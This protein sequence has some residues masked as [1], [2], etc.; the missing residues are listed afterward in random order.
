MRTV[1]TIFLK[2]L[3][4][5][6]RDR[7]TIITTVVVPLLLFPVIMGFT[8][9]IQRDATRKAHEKPLRV[10]V[11]SQDPVVEFTEILRHR[12]DITIVRDVSKENV[13]L[14]IKEEKLDGAYFFSDTYKNDIEGLR[15]GAVTFYFKSS[16]DENITK[17]RL[18]D[19]LMELEKL[20]LASRFEKLG[21]DSSITTPLSINEV[22]IATGKEIFGKIVGGLLPYIFVIFCF[23]GAMITAIDLGAGE[24]ER[25][26]L[27]TLLASPAG[28][29]EILGGKFMTVCLSGITSALLALLGLYAAFHFGVHTIKDLPPEIGSMLLEILEPKSV[30][31]FISML[32]PLTMFFSG[33]LLSISVYSKSFKEAGSIMGPVNIV[34]LLPVFI[35]MLPGI[36]LNSVTALVPLL[37][38]SLVSKEIFAGTLNVLFLAEAYASLI[39][40]AGFGLFVAAR[41]FSS[42]NVIFRT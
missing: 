17:S 23:M 19:S 35:G 14:L 3:K 2:E 33:I 41:F 20:E 6:L 22:D 13:D 27:E 34:I 24:K 18:R 32:L 4:D 12:G 42:E 37:N 21:L 16:G 8:V 9:K 40:I 11:I 26:T 25:G 31:L 39:L 30:S 38:V 5:V 29:L 36:E 1:L 7:R 15:P 28:R 10:A